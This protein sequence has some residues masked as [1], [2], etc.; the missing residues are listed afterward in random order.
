MCKNKPNSKYEV[1]KKNTAFIISYLIT[2]F[3]IFL[4]YGINY[5]IKLSFTFYFVWQLEN[6][7][8]HLSSGQCTQK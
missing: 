5:I 7:G 1:K 2:D 8:P 3:E 6:L 4:V